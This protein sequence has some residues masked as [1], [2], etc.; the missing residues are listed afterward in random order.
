ML[1][2]GL[3][4]S[5]CLSVRPSVTSRGIL[6]KRQHGSNWV[7]AYTGFS[8]RHCDREIT[9]STKIWGRPYFPLE[10]CPELCT[11]KIST[12][13][14]ANRRQTRYNTWRRRRMWPGAINAWT[15]RPSV[16]H[17]RRPAL[18]TAR[19]SR[20]GQSTSADTCCWLSSITTCGW[21]AC[22]RQT[23]YQYLSW[24]SLTWLDRRALSQQSN[25][26]YSSSQT[27]R[28]CYGNSCVIWD[29]SVTCH[30]A[31]VTF[32]PLPQPIEAGTRFIDPKR[33]KGWV[34]LVGWPA[35]DRL[36]TTVVTI[37]CRSSAGQGKFASQR[38]TFYHCAVQPTETLSLH[39]GGVQ[40][41][42]LSMSARPHNSKTT[43]P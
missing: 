13:H 39:L 11:Y 31:E 42:E 9:L 18:C 1:A 4:L 26:G 7:S 29:H 8:R 33:M 43:R 16:D 28:C 36:C 6:S 41:I 21:M 40:G 37:S 10:F 17:T 35:A 19:S 30:P 25:L 38:S 12:R 14:T 5:V 23:R 3:C 32:P 34:G 24:K 22:Q 2:M 27:P 15:D 20:I